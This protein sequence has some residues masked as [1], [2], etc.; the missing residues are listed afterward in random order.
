MPPRWLTA[1]MVRALHAESIAEF[2]GAGG[3]RDEGQLE[4]AL[5]RPQ[6]LLSYEPDTNLARLAA[7]YGFGLA[8]SHPFVDGNKRIAILAVA[9]FLALND[10]VF[11]PDEA[12]EVRTMIALTAGEIDE[13][14]F[15]A[16]IAAPMLA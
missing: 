12:D 6:H 5:A 8:R 2:G 16:W 11:D 10:R 15:A 7:A 14:E 1:A 9:V 4:S 13:L 3:I